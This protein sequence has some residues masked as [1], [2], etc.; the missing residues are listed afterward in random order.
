MTRCMRKREDVLTFSWSQEHRR[1]MRGADL[2]MATTMSTGEE[3][4]QDRRNAVE[5]GK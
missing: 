4:F 3:R 1:E 5:G 2:S